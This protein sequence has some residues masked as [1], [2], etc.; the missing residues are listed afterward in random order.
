MIEVKYRSEVK[1]F[2]ELENQ[3][4][5]Q[6]RDVIWDKEILYALN[7]DNKE[8]LSW[9]NKI[10]NISL[11]EK[12]NKF[13]DKVKYIKNP[14]LF[15]VVVKKP[16][17]QNTHVYLNYATYPAWWNI[18]DKRFEKYTH[19]LSENGNINEVYEKNIYPALKAIFIN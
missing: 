4:L 2:K 16:P 17:Q 9:K 15:Y 10:P 11:L 18:G 8:K 1:D 7:F 13:T 3:L 6:Y 5:W 14:L 12:I 19:Y